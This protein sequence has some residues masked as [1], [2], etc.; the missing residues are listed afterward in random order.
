MILGI[1]V[2]A[3]DFAGTILSIYTAVCL[4]NYL[5][6]NAHRTGKIKIAAQE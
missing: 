2:N 1:E 3:C 4:L 6:R 5:K